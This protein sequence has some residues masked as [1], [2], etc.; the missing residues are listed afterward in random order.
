MAITS[1]R[2][3]DQN[4][5][6]RTMQKY[7]HELK[8]DPGEIDGIFGRQT[9]WAV[10]WFQSMNNL[11]VDG[12]CGKKTRNR[13]ISNI[14]TEGVPNSRG[15]W[16]YGMEPLFYYMGDSR[17]SQ[18]PYDAKNTSKKETIGQSGCGPTTM[19]S[20]LTNL[21]G[22]AVLPP[23]LCD[24]SNAHGYRDPNG[25]DGTSPTFFRKCAEKYGLRSEIMSI[26]SKNPLKEWHFVKIQ[27]ALESGSLVACS[28]N[29]NSPYTNGGHYIMIWKIEDGKVYIKDPVKKN[30]KLEAFPIGKWVDGKWVKRFIRVGK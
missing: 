8:Y 9:Y 16:L 25:V 5:Y 1:L 3:G 26:T 7:L 13:M 20:I 4:S 12:I 2:E 11:R 19:A 14:A 29:G 27:T 23:V 17:W 30:N 22:R 28:V 24:W 15:V 6:V 10:K 21:L 18:Y